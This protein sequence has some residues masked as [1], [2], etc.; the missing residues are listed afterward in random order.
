MCQILIDLNVSDPVAH[1][2]IPYVVILVK[3]AKQWTKSHDGK[4][5]STWEDKRAF[6]VSMSS[7]I[8]YLSA[9]LFS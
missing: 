4:F 3:M 8:C 5:P 1:K 9:Y 7:S 6:K 2:H